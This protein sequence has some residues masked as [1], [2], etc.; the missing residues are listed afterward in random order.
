MFLTF[1]VQLASHDPNPN[2]NR[3][4][5]ARYNATELIG[6]KFREGGATKQNSV[7]KSGFSLNGVHAFSE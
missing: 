2:P 3:N 6:T 5:I 4:R 1:Y 7:N